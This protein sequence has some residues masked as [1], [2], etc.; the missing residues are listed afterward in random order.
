MRSSKSVVQCPTCG[1]TAKGYPYCNSP[2]DATVKIRGAIAKHL[3][4]YSSI[5]V[6]RK[7]WFCGYCP[8]AWHNK[9]K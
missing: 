3:H 7:L 8:D 6:E 5:D 4:Q 9:R 2:Y 1:S